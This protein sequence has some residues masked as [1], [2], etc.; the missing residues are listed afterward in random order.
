VKG[1]LF[2]NAYLAECAHGCQGAGLYEDIAAVRPQVGKR[3]CDLLLRR[4]GTE[5]HWP[6][7]RP[8]HQPSLFFALAPLSRAHSNRARTRLG[9]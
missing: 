4:Q 5:R 7:R 8:F 9:L 6:G 2:R 3:L 1:A